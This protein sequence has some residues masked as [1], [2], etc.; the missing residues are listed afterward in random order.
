MF[1]LIGFTVAA[2]AAAV[3]GR[4]F[5]PG[6]WYKALSKPA[7]RPPD[8]LFAPV[9]GLLYATIAVSGWLVWREAGIIGAAVPLA[10]YILQLALNACWSPVFFGLHRPDI[11]LVEILALWLSIAATIVLFY[12]VH[13][14]AAALLLPYLAW[15]SFASVL[16]YSIWRRN[17]SSGTEPTS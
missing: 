13:A 7:W 4:V 11:A 2:F 1:M 16:N 3:P 5:R 15:V 14:G 9:W 17:P 8:W 10:V 6:Q 12:P